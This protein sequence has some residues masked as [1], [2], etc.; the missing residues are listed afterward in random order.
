MELKP[1]CHRRAIYGATKAV[2]FLTTHVLDMVGAVAVTTTLLLGRLVGN[3]TSSFPPCSLESDPRS[4][5]ALTVSLPKFFHL[6][7]E[8]CQLP[9]EQRERDQTSIEYLVDQI[10]HVEVLAELVGAV[11]ND[12]LEL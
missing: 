4:I 12:L 3:A 11:C 1:V 2:L 10:R 9:V 7:G 5:C 8:T 6:I